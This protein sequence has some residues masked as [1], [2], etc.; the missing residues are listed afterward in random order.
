MKK[1]KNSK[2]QIEQ[3]V[4]NLVESDITNLGY[5]LWDVEYYNDGV[6]WLLEIT[7][8]KPTGI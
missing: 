7:I 5:E 4:K 3:T 1:D 6:E 2:K 8:D